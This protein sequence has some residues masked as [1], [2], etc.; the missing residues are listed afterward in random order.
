MVTSFPFSLYSPSF[1]TRVVLHEKSR[2]QSADRKRTR[3]I[4]Y[5]YNNYLLLS[6]A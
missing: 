6:V 4:S 5:K 3:F 1:S 2:A